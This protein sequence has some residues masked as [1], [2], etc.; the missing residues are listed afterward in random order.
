V[1]AAAGQSVRIPP[2]TVH[3]FANAGPVPARVAVE[4]R[5]ALAMEDLLETAA[6]MAQEQHAAG[7][8]LPRPVEL[9]LFMADFEREVRAPFL[10]AGLVRPILRR[11]ARLARRRGLDERYRQLRPGRASALVTADDRD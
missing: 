4:S 11:L 10:P 3:H 7:R 1:I 5:P 9:A 8:A 2:G 6:A